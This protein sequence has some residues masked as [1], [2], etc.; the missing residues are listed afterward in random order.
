VV[1]TEGVLATLPE[2]RRASQARKDWERIPVLAG[3]YALTGEARYRDAY[4][5]FLTAWLDLYAISGNPIDE[6]HLDGWLLAY[7]AAGASLPPELQ[8]RMQKFACDLADRYSQPQSK[9][10]SSSTNNWQS[11]RA[12]LAVMG[13]LT[14][15]RPEGIRRAEAVFAA[16][17]RDNLRPDGESIDFAQRDAIHYVVYSIEPLL[18]AALFSEQAGRPLFAV[19]GPGG[20]SLSRGLQWLAPYA[21]GE[22]SH[23]EFVRSQVRFDA[24]RAAA[25][26]AGFSGRFVPT[27]ARWTFWL[28]ARL[29]GQWEASSEALGLPEIAQR[30]AWQ[31]R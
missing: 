6:T 1:H 10:K 27:K 4:A 13:A 7:R 16:Q 14:C 9:G 31:I 24:E 12:K 21:R 30:I 15:G 11:H 26:V 17:I 3:A 22:K 5:R 23:E 28:A 29:D 18:E 20:Q 19:V 25:G 8:D 2:Y